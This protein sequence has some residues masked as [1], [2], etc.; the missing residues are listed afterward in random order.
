MSNWGF[1]TG[2]MTIANKGPILTSL[3]FKTAEEAGKDISDFI[4]TSQQSTLDN[5][6]QELTQIAKENPH[7]PQGSEG[8]LKFNIVQTNAPNVISNMGV[9]IMGSLR[10]VEGEKMIK[11]FM[12]WLKEVFGPDALDKFNMEVETA[13]FRI[14]AHTLDRPVLVTFFEDTGWVFGPALQKDIWTNKIN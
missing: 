3:D 5:Q 14:D 8:K 12:T 2:S 10:D 4:T 9:N 13:I 7:I 1:I 11:Q 6:I